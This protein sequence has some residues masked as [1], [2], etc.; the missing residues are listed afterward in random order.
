MVR[1]TR[2][3]PL[4]YSDVG[5]T[6]VTDEC[7]IEPVGSAFRVLDPWNEYLVDLFPTREAAQLDFDRCKR[8]DQMYETAQ[9]LVDAAIE[10]QI[11]KFRIH[12]EVA[13]YWIH[14]VMGG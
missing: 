8:E 4:R 10:A 12:R 11:Q 6:T 14:S 1:K 2:P 13:K 5:V 3:T 7:R 9:Q